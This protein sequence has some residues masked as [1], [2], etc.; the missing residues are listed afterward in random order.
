M[1]ETTS[2]EV[3]ID[4]QSRPA[5]GDGVVSPLPETPPPRRSPRK[6]KSSDPPATTIENVGRKRPI[7][8]ID[9]PKIA[10]PSP[11]TSSVTDH[12]DSSDS[13]FSAALQYEEKYI[14]HNSKV[15]D[16]R[17]RKR[18]GPTKAGRPKRGP[19]TDWYQSVTLDDCEIEMVPK[20][21]DGQVK[22]VPKV[23]TILRR[24]FKKDVYFLELRNM[25]T[26]LKIEGYKNRSKDDV[27]ELIA[28]KKHN[29]SVYNAMFARHLGGKTRKEVQCPFCEINIVFSDA[30][31]D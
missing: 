2:T 17:A 9:G 30:F 24:D 22:H 18:R 21:V 13:P 19:D 16:G 28:A 31:A 27:L 14:L 11:E 6:H 4:Q 15:G 8:F 7:F 3:V 12:G 20:V 23:K 26:I 25:C 1:M 5:E 29:Q 10:G